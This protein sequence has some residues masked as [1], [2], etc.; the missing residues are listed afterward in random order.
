MFIL[1]EG[2]IHSF[3]QIYMDGR[4][5][6]AEL[7]PSWVGHSIG[8]FEKDT[9]VIDS[10]GFNDKFWFDHNGTPH[11]EQLHTIERW[12][13]LDLG[14]LENKVTIDDPGAYSRPWTVTFMARL[15]APGDEL[16]EYICQENNQYGIAG[17]HPNPFAQ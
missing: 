3:R 4:K 8:S 12:T 17:G 15:Q 16:M 11:T 14:R 1:H 6:P 10:V 7:D 5:H 13:R 2:N 9:L